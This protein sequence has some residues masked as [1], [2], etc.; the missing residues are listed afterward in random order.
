MATASVT[1]CEIDG[2]TR[3]GS[4]LDRKWCEKHYY[5][6]YR[7]GDPTYVSL[8]R[9]SVGDWRVRHGN[10]YTTPEGY[11]VM[12][13]GDKSFM[14]HRLVIGGHLGRPLRKDETVHHL[15][16]VKDDNR[17]ENLQLRS[18][19]HGK[20]AAAVCGSCGSHDVRFVDLDGGVV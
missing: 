19:R 11:R 12:V 2:C 4:R 1:K 17:I 3:V 13:W 15:N 8:K 14:E 20:G 18:G 9:R 7:Y 6:N 10:F 5:R 16:G